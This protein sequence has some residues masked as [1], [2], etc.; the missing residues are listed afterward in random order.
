MN[1]E[2]RAILRDIEHAEAM[3]QDR[4]VFYYLTAPF[5]DNE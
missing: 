4:A 3:A 1:A 2:A 5:Q